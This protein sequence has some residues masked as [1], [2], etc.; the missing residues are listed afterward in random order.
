MLSDEI[1]RTLSPIGAT[2]PPLGAGADSS[3]QLVSDNRQDTHSSGY[4]LQDY[5]S[6]WEDSTDKPVPESKDSLPA[7]A[8]ASVPQKEPNPEPQPPVLQVD[9]PASVSIMSPL[10]DETPALRKRFSWEAGFEHNASAL[11]TEAPADEPPGTGIPNTDGVSIPKIDTASSLGQSDVQPP[12]EVVSDITSPRSETPKIV[13]PSAPE[14][15]YAPPPAQPLPSMLDPP[16][17]VAA[18]P[19]E[20]PQ[21]VEERRPSALSDNVPSESLSHVVLE[22]SPP[23][24]QTAVANALLTQPRPIP[25]VKGVKE[26]MAMGTS[27]KRIHE[28]EESRKAFAEADLGLETWILA[29]KQ[30]HPEFANVTSSFNG[31]GGYQA[32]IAGT[33][34]AA[35]NASSAPAQAPYYQQ[36]LNATSP[37][38]T[39]PP[40]TTRTRLGSSSLS[41]QATSAF[42]NSSNQIGTKSKEFMHS[43][44]KMGKGLLSK[45]RSKLRGTGDKVF[46]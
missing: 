31:G 20:L 10:S 42:G 25:Q 5:D 23:E 41:T 18:R 8:S 43:A 17:P 3:K 9:G 12:K 6:Y 19:E 2:P 29:I 36:Y 26:I 38:P 34:V 15:N 14:I 22:T 24:T 39:G 40:P 1:L 33:S 4:T 13:I 30:Q 16:S 32:S 21:D 11:M 37:A 45:G 44:G 35:S 46:H 27:E 7:P 28:Y